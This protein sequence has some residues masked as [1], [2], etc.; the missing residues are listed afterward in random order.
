[1]KPLAKRKFQILRE[2]LNLVEN[3]FLAKRKH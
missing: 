2:K 1:M 3:I